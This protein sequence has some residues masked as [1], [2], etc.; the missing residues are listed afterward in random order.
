MPTEPTTVDHPAMPP[1][2]LEL[3]DALL[4]GDHT[5]SIVAPDGTSFEV[6]SDGRRLRVGRAGDLVV[7]HPYASRDHA[8][9]WNAEGALYVVDLGSRNGTTVVRDGEALGA[10]R[11]VAL[12]PGDTVVTIAG[13]VLLR[14]DAQ[15]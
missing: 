7:A 14:V 13:T 10:E 4:D 6:P 12:R 2:W 3:A 9:V 11:P 8:A 1:M 15:A 5:P